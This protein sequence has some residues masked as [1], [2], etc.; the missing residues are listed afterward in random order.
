MSS[1]L[2]GIRRASGG[3]HHPAEQLG[4]VSAV[5]RR[6]E[7]HQ[8]LRTRAVPARGDRALGQQDLE[9]LGVL[10][11]LRLDVGND[12]LA[13]GQ[14]LVFAEDVGNGVVRQARPRLVDGVE[15]SHEGLLRWLVTHL[16]DQERNHN[17]SSALLLRVLRP[18]GGRCPDLLDG[19]GQQHR[20]ERAVLGGDRQSDV[21]LQ[22]P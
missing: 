16:H 1:S 3:A 19:L 12:L 7:R 9:V 5:L 6:T 10:D 2:P 20:V 18:R 14:V 8:H 22:Q 11:P 21:V 15:R 13:H 4:D 17:L